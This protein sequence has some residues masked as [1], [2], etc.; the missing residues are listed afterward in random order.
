MKTMPSA[1]FEPRWSS[2]NAFGDLDTNVRD[3]ALPA[4]AARVGVHTGLVLIGPELL[5]GGGAELSAIGEAV[6][7]AA[8]LQAEATPGSVVISQETSRLVEG[9]FSLV[10]MGARPIKG[11]SR[12]IVIY[13]VVAPLPPTDQRSSS[14]SASSATQMVGRRPT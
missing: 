9:R 1:R 14:G 12:K 8:R 7:L 2:S 10:E 4:L 6:N 5:S 3:V 13:R 11:L